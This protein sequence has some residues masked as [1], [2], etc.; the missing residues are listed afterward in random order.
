ML[1]RLS[2]EDVSQVSPTLGFGIK[3]FSFPT[4]SGSTYTLNVWDVG[5]QRTLRPYWRNYFESTDAV[6]WVVDSADRHRIE[7][8]RQELEGLLKEERLAGATLLVLANKQDVSNA[9]TSDEIREVSGASLALGVSLMRPQAL[10]L[11][12][13][14]THRWRIQPCSAYAECSSQEGKLLLDGISWLVKD[15]AERIY[16]STASG[17]QESMLVA[18]T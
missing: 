1:K 11:P 17:A 18:A 3:S 10:A 7:D 5:G 14:T 2:G 9:M 13:V 16:Y 8:C 15:V 6:V 12:A 4:S